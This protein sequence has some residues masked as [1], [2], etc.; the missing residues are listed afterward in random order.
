M[1]PKDA[2]GMA[3]SADPE[4]SDKG[5]HCLL[6]STCP[7]TMKFH[8]VYI[9]KGENLRHDHLCFKRKLSRAK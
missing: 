3:N 4:Q 1:H 2:D 6:R 5:L 7:D 9:P 8:K